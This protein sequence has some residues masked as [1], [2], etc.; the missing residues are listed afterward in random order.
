MHI[1][2]T[3]NKD[4]EKAQALYAKSLFGFRKHH[5]YMVVS[6]QK[7]YQS[8]AVLVFRGLNRQDGHHRFEVSMDYMERL[9]LKAEIRFSL[10]YAVDLTGVLIKTLLANQSQ[11]PMTCKGPRIMVKAFFK[12]RQI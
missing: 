1:T 12:G 9:C 10:K 11:V 7:W 2:Q 6:W 4:P 8:P 3:E 5:Y